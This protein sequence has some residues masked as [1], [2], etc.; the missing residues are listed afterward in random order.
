MNAL[1]AADRFLVFSIIDSLMACQREG[2]PLRYF[3]QM[4]LM[5]FDS[6]KEYG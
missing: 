6:P 2:L 1:P 3:Q 5:A 4:L